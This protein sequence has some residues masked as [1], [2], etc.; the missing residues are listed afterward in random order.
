[1]NFNFREFTRQVVQNIPF[2]NI[3]DLTKFL[4]ELK[5]YMKN[6]NQIYIL[7]ENEKDKENFFSIKQG[8]FK[9]QLIKDD[10]HH[11]YKKKIAILFGSNKYKN[12]KIKD[13]TMVEEDVGLMK[14]ALGLHGF[15]VFV[16]DDISKENILKNLKNIKEMSDEDTVVVVY[17]SGHG[18]AYKNR[19]IEVEEVK[20]EDEETYK[21]LYEGLLEKIKKGKEKKDEIGKKVLK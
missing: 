20:T 6:G 17:M 21:K 19:N 18:F 15:E 3:N 12:E 14:I 13:L 9:E 2:E 7:D 10:E 8:E 16:V 1:M 4:K 11:K 5:E